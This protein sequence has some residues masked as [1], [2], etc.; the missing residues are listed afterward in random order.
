MQ[1][2]LF[3]DL[4]K[5]GHRFS[6]IEKE[7]EM[8]QNYLS[9]FKNPENKLPKKWMTPLQTYLQRHTLNVSSQKAN[10]PLSVNDKK[11]YSPF[12]N[13]TFNAKLSK[14]KKQD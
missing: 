1:E 5:L 14:S 3:K 8:P 7:L 12:N 9:R 13:P 11:P 4:E 2:Q 6:N 10:Y